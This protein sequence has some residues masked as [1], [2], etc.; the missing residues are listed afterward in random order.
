[1]GRETGWGA[2]WG[3]RVTERQK[4][5]DAESGRVTEREKCQKEQQSDEEES[6]KKKGDKRERAGRRE[7]LPPASSMA[8]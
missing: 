5:R 3:D 8:G 4:N 1:M 2:Q 6:E 7:E